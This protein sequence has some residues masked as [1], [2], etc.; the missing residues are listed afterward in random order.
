[1]SRPRT[2]TAFTLIP[3]VHPV[4]GKPVVVIDFG[5]FGRIALDADDVQRFIAA[6]EAKLREARALG[7]T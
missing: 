5:R 3:Q 4:D 7:T 2:P 1:V 6:L